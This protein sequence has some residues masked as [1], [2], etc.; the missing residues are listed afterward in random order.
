MQPTPAQQKKKERMLSIKKTKK[1][2]D[3][4]RTKQ[5]DAKY[6]TPVETT[7]VETTPVYT[8]R[9][10]RVISCVQRLWRK[11]KFNTCLKAA[12]HLISKYDIKGRY[13]KPG[14]D[15]LIRFSKYSGRAQW[16]CY[17]Y[18]GGLITHGLCKRA[19]V[20]ELVYAYLQSI[21]HQPIISS[22]KKAYNGSET[23]TQPYNMED[24]DLVYTNLLQAQS[25]TKCRR[26]AITIQRAF[27]KKRKA[28][29]HENI[30]S[31]DNYSIRLNLHTDTIYGAKSG[32]EWFKLPQDGVVYNYSRTV[33][34]KN[35]LFSTKYIL[36]KCSAPF[37]D[38]LYKECEWQLSWDL[39]HI[40]CPVHYNG[41]SIYIHLNPHE[42]SLY[43]NDEDMFYRQNPNLHYKVREI[44]TDSLPDLVSGYTQKEI[45]CVQAIQGWYRISKKRRNYLHPYATRIQRKWRLY[46]VRRMRPFYL[47]QLPTT[48]SKPYLVR[49]F[50]MYQWKQ[51]PSFRMVY[52]LANNDVIT[53]DCAFQGGPTSV[54]RMQWRTK[55]MSSLYW[56][57]T[58]DTTRRWD[59]GR[60]YTI[61]ITRDMHKFGYRW[62]APE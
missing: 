42:F 35:T 24:H 29:H 38:G 27:L 25:L 22:W 3:R 17:C 23:V 48:D 37:A 52:I 46:M 36:F 43:N 58:P 55:D 31:G 4:H 61:R 28:D 53:K 60:D 56:N 2:K 12:D 9:Q 10:L 54:T 59:Y 34:E 30:M 45:N 49:P 8:E 44:D 21:G 6:H 5:R 16:R 26:A 47:V 15:A 13:W 19:V 32:E 40:K 1:I 39:D 33:I 62:V 11:N 7:P 50:M 57:P 18:Q 51:K 41:K 20:Q 14:V